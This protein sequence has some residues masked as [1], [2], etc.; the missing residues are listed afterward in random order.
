MKNFERNRYRLEIRLLDV[1]SCKNYLKNQSSFYSY[2]TIFA[3]HNH[4]TKIFYF[5]NKDIFK[6]SVINPKL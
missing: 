3:S 2:F 5:R 1:E 6:F 4:R